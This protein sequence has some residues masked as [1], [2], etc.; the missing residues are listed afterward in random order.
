MFRILLFSLLTLAGIAPLQAQ[1][2]QIGWQGGGNFGYPAQ[3]GN[4]IYCATN[5]AVYRSHDFGKNWVKFL[6]GLPI[7]TSFFNS[8]NF[9]QRGQHLIIDNYREYN[10]SDSNFLE[11]GIYYCNETDSNWSFKKLSKIYGVASKILFFSSDTFFAFRQ[12]NFSDVD[13]LDGFYLSTNNGLSWERRM[14]D[15]LLSPNTSVFAMSSHFFLS[16]D[17]YL[18]RSDNFG[19]TWER[20]AARK[21][22][23]NF[24]TVSDTE[25][26]EQIYPPL[27][28]TSLIAFNR[29]TNIG[30]TWR[31]AGIKLPYG[32][33]LEQINFCNPIGSRLFISLGFYPDRSNYIIFESNYQKGIWHRIDFHDSTLVIGDIFGKENYYVLVT[34]KGYFTADS[35]FLTLTPLFPLGIL[36]NYRQLV[37]VSGTKLFA[38]LDWGKKLSDSLMVSTDNGSTWAKELFF[39]QN[40]LDNHRWVHAGNNLYVSGFQKDSLPCIFRSSDEGNTWNIETML[41]THDAIARFF[42]EGDTIV[43]RRENDFLLSIDKGKSWVIITSPAV[44][45][46]VN[47]DYRNGI[48]EILYTYQGAVAISTDFGATWKNSNP[49]YNFGYIYYGPYIFGDRLFTSDGSQL[50]YRNLEDILW[51]KSNGLPDKIIY[52]PYTDVNGILYATYYNF[53]SGQPSSEGHTA[54]YYSLDSG[55]NWK[56]L[57]DYV[58]NSP[59]VFISSDYIFLAGPTELWRGPKPTIPSGVVQTKSISSISI[60]ECYPNP[61]KSEMHISYSIPKRSDIVLSVFDITGKE[62]AK[63]TNES[64]DTGSFEK[65]WNVQ[66]LANGSY[67]LK[68]TACGESVTKVVEVV[69]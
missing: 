12:K 24:F 36:F 17:V 63:I 49:F 11:T 68:L 64:H 41:S 18:F 1:W 23:S 37:A 26:L 44:W 59:D 14:V 51:K 28:D 29:S 5:N 30:N 43:V 69:K 7:N 58:T 32:Q 19:Y 61:A 56:Q 50:Y 39:N 57:G 4:T 3:L 33:S 65:L 20:T 45:S 16:N 62:I 27:N 22:A 6:D 40:K 66:T 47:M 48:F 52:L 55:A 67:I 15:S 31:D 53:S 38:L 54:L 34:S 46:S 60:N 9:V 10:S 21:Y 2:E 25:L 35:T 13:S 8:C 42:V